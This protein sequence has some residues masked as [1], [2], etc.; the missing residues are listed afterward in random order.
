MNRT[1]EYLVT[2][3]GLEKLKNEL[4]WRLKEERPRLADLVEEMRDKGDISENDGY[5]LAKDQFE[6]N[7][8]DI[9]RLEEMIRNSKVVATTDTKGISLGNTVLVEDQ[10]GTERTFELVGEDEADPMNGKISYK[11]PLGEAMVEKKAGDSFE[12]ET[13]SG[14]VRY[15]IKNVS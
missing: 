3:D 7:E 2:Q 5:S 13:P 4:N 10:N 15:S 8:Q 6:S 11:S 14:K 9:A 1:E 12:F